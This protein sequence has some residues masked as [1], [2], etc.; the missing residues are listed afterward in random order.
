MGVALSVTIVLASGWPPAPAFA[1]SEP[2]GAPLS[3]PD[4]A[5]SPMLPP[6][7]AP[8]VLG[9]LTPPEPPVS[10]TASTPGVGAGPGGDWE[11]EHPTITPARIRISTG[12]RLVRGMTRIGAVL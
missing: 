4:P 6:L 10:A 5:D 12:L 2:V 7:P 1:S 8:P 11:E 3:P 9:A